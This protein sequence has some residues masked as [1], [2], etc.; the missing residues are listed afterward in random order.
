VGKSIFE[1]CVMGKLAN[2]T[3]LFVTHQLQFLPTVDYIVVVKDGAITERGTYSEL[4]DSKKEFYE[5]IQEHI[6]KKQNEVS[7]SP[8]VTPRG[9]KVKYYI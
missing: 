5:L 9:E 6:H 8:Q 4:M 3:R 7:S 2:K 1:K